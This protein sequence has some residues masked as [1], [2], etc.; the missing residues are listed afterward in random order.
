M[1]NQLAIFIDFENIA[2]WAEREYYDF[3][4]TPVMEYI[5]SRGPAVVKRAYGDWS[6]FSRYRDELMN[7]SI[8]LIQIF[9]VRAGKNRADIRMAIDALETAMTHPQIQNFVLVS[10]DSDFSPLAAKLREYGRYTLGVGPRTIT[11]DL[12]VKSCDEFVYLETVLGD[13]DEADVQIFT[14]REDARRQL[15]KALQVHAQRSELPIQAAKLKQTMLL[16]D[17]AFNEANFGHSQFKTWL[18][19]NQDI[20]KLYLQD[21]HLYVA[22]I[23]YHAPE[24]LNLT[25]LDNQPV[26][27]EPFSNN[28]PAHERQYR[29]LFTRLKMTSADLATR[30]D[31]LRDVYRELVE[32]PGKIVSEDLLEMLRER[33]V[34]QDMIRSKPLLHDILQMA[35]RQRAFEFGK[36]SASLHSPMRLVK[37]IDSEAAFVRRAESDFVYAVIRA[38]LEIDPEE[39]ACIVLNDRDQ[40]GYIDSLIDELKQRGLIVRKDSRYLLAGRDVIPFREELILKPLCRDIESVKLPE[41]IEQ[42]VNMSKI[43]ARN[44]MVQR[45]EDFEAAAHNFLLA[46]RLQWDA[47]E[48]NDSGAS[49]QDLRWYMASYASANAGRLSQVNKDYAAA[50]P[51]YLAFFALVQEDD[52]LW[53]RMRGLINPMLAYYWVN[54]AREFGIN[55][56]ELNFSAASP[57]Q[58]VVAV[59]CHPNQKLRNYWREV[60]M[61]LAKVNPGLLQRVA[62]Q[63][64]NSRAESPEYVQV[65]D[66]LRQ[67]ASQ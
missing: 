21:L 16:I 50:R 44:A 58:I 24:H 57:L 66:Q 28:Q 59:A 29:Q 61:S 48:R 8:D 12:L 51:Y 60:S 31:V 27:S 13:T 43:L 34:A 35:H 39:L 65:A 10:G 1:E 41:G 45:S 32:K 54:I 38:G 33:Y 20:V 6:R 25:L 63:L 15:R 11:H 56:N 36:E 14:E 46:C 4:L 26:M 64:V 53:D 17:P 7:L 19:E 18:E 30:R 2:L 23:D 9:S 42:G 22:P 5:Q 49:L 3:E 40:G 55:T 37:G 52:P 62:D 47:V 67:M